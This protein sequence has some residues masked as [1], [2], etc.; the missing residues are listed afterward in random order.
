MLTGSLGMLPSASLG[1]ADAQGRR[2]ALYEPVHGS[3]PDIAGRNLANPLALIRSAILMLYHLGK[4]EVARRVG[5]A[6]RQ[7]IVVDR[8]LTRDLGGEA[9]TSQFTEAVV[10]AL[11]GGIEA[12]ALGDIEGNAFS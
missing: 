11:E 12:P 9:S 10:A 4:D 8:V 5:A 7:V 2:R 1:A 3:A 6:V